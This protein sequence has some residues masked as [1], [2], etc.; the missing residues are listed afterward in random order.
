MAH[1]QKSVGLMRGHGL[2]LASVR[3]EQTLPNSFWSKSDTFGF[4][5]LTL[6]VMGKCTLITNSIA[7]TCCQQPMTTEEVG[8]TKQE[9][10]TKGFRFTHF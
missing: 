6:D 4:F 8:N 3:G 2:K 10:L 5:E 7:N 9:M 1:W